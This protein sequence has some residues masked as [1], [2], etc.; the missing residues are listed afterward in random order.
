[1]QCS[2]MRCITSLARQSASRIIEQGEGEQARAKSSRL[3][4]RP[5]PRVDGLA[6]VSEVEVEPEKFG[7]LAKVEAHVAP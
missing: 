4:G 6:S 7:H 5:L 1:M 2:G 3:A